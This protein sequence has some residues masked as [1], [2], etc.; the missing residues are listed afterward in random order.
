LK[1]I[2][3]FLIICFS[4][5]NF[6]QEGFQFDY[7]V[8]KV[9][10]PVEIINNLVFIKAM[11]N[12]VEVTLLLD[13]G[14][15]ETVIFSY[16]DKPLKLNN[17]E[18]V[19]IKGF[20]H[21]DPFEGYKTTNNRIEIKDF[22][23]RNQTIYLVLDEDINFSSMVGIPV[24][25]IIGYEFFKNYPVKI[26]YGKSIITV[27]NQ[28]NLQI[29]NA[30]TET[31]P[32]QFI[33]GK[34]FINCNVFQE[35]E[36]NINQG[37]FLVD[38]GNSDAVWLFKKNNNEVTIPSI[39]IEDYLGKG[40]SGVVSGK[41][42]RLK[43][44][45]LSKFDIETPISAYPDSLS[46]A[47]LNIAED[48]YGSIG[49][50]IMRRFTTTFDYKN[51]KMYIKP[52]K[53]LNAPFEYDM[54]GLEIVHDGLEWAAEKYE[55]KPAIANNLYDAQGEKIS[56]NLKFKFVLKPVFKITLVRKESTAAIAG[57]LVN[58][59]LIAINKK[60]CSEM[61]LQDINAILKSAD[62]KNIKLEIERDNKNIEINFQ[63]KRML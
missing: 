57:V 47:M 55:D 24:N 27:Y 59:I 22:I 28:E 17:L 40:L 34:P 48:R 35:S 43:K 6:S 44:L 30:K 56:G 41:R 8:S 19:L 38:T 52:N 1:K 16:E 10:I 51:K 21:K 37:L 58:D 29:K 7:N 33:S 53:Y 36:K 20:G 50:E 61:N 63:L 60:S 15:K 26:D 18:K 42:A 46:L 4:I 32:L 54:S 5:Q 12:D 9:K 45:Q 62:Q 13:T 11:V 14:V 31:I 39:H 2:V 49:A 23:D 25:G 3:F